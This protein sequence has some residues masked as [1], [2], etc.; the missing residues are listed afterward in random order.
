VRQKKP[1][2]NVDAHFRQNIYEQLREQ[3]LDAGR[4]NWDHGLSI[5]LSRG[6]AAWMQQAGERPVSWPATAQSAF[7]LP[8]NELVSVLAAL[9]LGQACPTATVEVCHD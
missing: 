6:L 7:D 5:L 1:V 9:V 8:H 3:A 4:L 2:P